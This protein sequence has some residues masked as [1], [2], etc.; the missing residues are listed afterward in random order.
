MTM[1]A[2]AIVPHEFY[3]VKTGADP[4]TLLSSNKGPHHRLIRVAETIA[5]RFI[6]V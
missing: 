6:L 1:T 5:D 3:Y 4:T 2:E